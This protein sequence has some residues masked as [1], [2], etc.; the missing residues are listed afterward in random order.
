[1]H[2]LVQVLNTTGKVICT[3]VD[4]TM[5]AGTYTVDFE[6]VN[7]PAGTYYIRLQNMELSQVKSMTVVKG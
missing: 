3:L 1:M 7:Y 4:R 5:A 6:N 2:T